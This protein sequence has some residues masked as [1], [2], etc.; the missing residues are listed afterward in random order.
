[1][2]AD[3]LCNERLVQTTI[4]ARLL[5]IY[6]KTGAPCKDFGDNGTVQLSQ[7]IGEVKTGYYFQ[8][9]APLISRNLIVVGGW[10]TDNQEVGEPSGVI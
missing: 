10:V 5:A 4:Y 3:G 9:S 1:Q 6:S 8:T 2:S 7:G